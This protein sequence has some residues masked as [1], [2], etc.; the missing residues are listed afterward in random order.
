MFL[1]IYLELSLRYRQ[2]FYFLLFIS[3]SA[4]KKIK[5]NKTYHVQQNMIS[6]ILFFFVDSHPVLQGSCIIESINLKYSS[7]IL[8]NFKYKVQILSLNKTIYF[9]NKFEIIDRVKYNNSLS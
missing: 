5:I 6:H 8:H 3:R 4:L 1:F 9:F 7:L 2:I